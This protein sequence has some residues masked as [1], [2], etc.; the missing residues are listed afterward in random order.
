ML[1]WKN[2]MWK[3]HY[4]YFSTTWRKCLNSVN[5]ETVKVYKLKILFGYVQ[6]F[7]LF[8]NCW[9]IRILVIVVRCPRQWSEEFMTS[10]NDFMPFIGSQTLEVKFLKT[11]CG[12]K[13]KSLANKS[14]S[15]EP[16]FL[17]FLHY[18]PKEVRVLAN[19]IFLVLG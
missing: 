5:C 4:T 17:H 14:N 8:N 18:D 6:Q 12:A 16:P 1:K 2:F 9:F 11:H 10:S 15:Q 19:L 13:F 7:T 3:N